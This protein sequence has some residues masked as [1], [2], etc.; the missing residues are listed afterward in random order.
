ML[1]DYED[2][3]QHLHRHMDRAAERYA[4]GLKR[5]GLQHNEKLAKAVANR[6]YEEARADYE[7]Q[8]TETFLHNMQV[9][10][11]QHRQEEN[12]IKRE[13]ASRRLKTCPPIAAVF[14]VMAWYSW[15]HPGPDHVIIAMIYAI[16]ALAF[17]TMLV[18]GAIFDR[19]R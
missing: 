7:G 14:A 9:L 19:P 4:D 11:E 13:T 18:L 10:D 15:S 8:S 6:V 16:G 5:T 17:L 12:K 2:P 1:R 3:Q